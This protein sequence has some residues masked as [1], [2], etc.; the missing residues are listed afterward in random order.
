MVKRRRWGAA[1]AA[2][3][4]TSVLPT[5]TAPSATAGGASGLRLIRTTDEVVERRF[6]SGYVSLDPRMLL[7]AAGGNFEIQASRPDYDTP[8]AVIWN[9]PGGGSV[10]LPDDVI[11]GWLGL[12][13]FLHVTVTDRN[14]VAHYDRWTSFFPNTWE[15]S[16]SVPTVRRSR[17][18]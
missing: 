10:A 18:I 3:M 12:R 7:A 14:G 15:N 6:R 8:V 11:D 16:V 13:R 1:L 5:L 9:M 2:V 17:S 4:L